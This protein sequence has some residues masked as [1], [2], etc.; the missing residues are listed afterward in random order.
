MI[1]KVNKRSK[2]QRH[3]DA[4]IWTKKRGKLSRGD[5]YFFSGCPCFNEH[6]PIL[7]NLLWENH[8]YLRCSK[9]P[10]FGTESFPFW[11]IFCAHK[12]FTITSISETLKLAFPEHIIF[13]VHV[14]C[15]ILNSNFVS[16]EFFRFTLYDML[17]QCTYHTEVTLNTQNYV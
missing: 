7:E 3:K 8:W 15:T 6:A 1:S 2:K 10:I 16:I 5:Y 9:I 11:D 4:I 13:F 17:N 12:C 14:S